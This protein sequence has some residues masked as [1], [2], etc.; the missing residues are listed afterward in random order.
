[1]GSR[2]NHAVKTDDVFGSRLALARKRA[3]VTQAELAAALG[4]RYDQTMVSAV[5]RGRAALRLDG[6]VRA[7]QALGVSLDYLTGLTDNPRPRRA[8]GGAEPAQA[9][10]GW[11]Q[12][13][14]RLDETVKLAET[15]ERQSDARWRG[16]G[17]RVLREAVMNLREWVRRSTERL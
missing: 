14:G 17:V 5:E 12:V 1:M 2:V 6:A 11:P 4:D 16:P 8:A 3:H 15:L 13:L 9:P 10:I 7:A